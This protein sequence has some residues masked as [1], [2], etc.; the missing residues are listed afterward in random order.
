MQ[1]RLE[2]PIQLHLAGKERNRNLHKLNRRPATP[3]QEWFPTRRPW[4]KI[5]CSFKHLTGTSFRCREN[6][7]LAT[8]RPTRSSHLFIITYTDFQH[9]ISRAMF[10]QGV[11]ST[12][13]LERYSMRVPARRPSLIPLEPSRLGTRKQPQGEID[14]EVVVAPGVYP[15]MV[16]NG[17]LH[18]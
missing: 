17:V 10:P 11:E 5:H 8:L 4:T 12:V 3:E 6:F 14:V 7:T 18:R 9:G 15:G 13:R 16:P 2:A 1:H